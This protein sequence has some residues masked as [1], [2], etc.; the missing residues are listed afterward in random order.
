ML[1]WI[2]GVSFRKAQWKYITLVGLAVV[3]RPT[4]VIVWLP[5][6]LWHLVMYRPVMW[7]VIKIFAERGY[8]MSKQFVKIKFVNCNRL[9]LVNISSGYACGKVI[10]G[11]LG[12][13]CNGLRASQNVCPGFFF[14][15]L[16]MK[17]K[18]R[19]NSLSVVRLR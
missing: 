13:L 19:E 1:I 10:I 3:I 17:S 6:C 18:V 4:A 2:I 9:F 14:V 8:V 5:L 7:R 16:E 11:Y 12:K 15:I